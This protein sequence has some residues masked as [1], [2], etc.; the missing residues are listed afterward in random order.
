MGQRDSWGG[1][2]A[3]PA[4]PEARLPG[5]LSEPWGG[6][7][8]VLGAGGDVRPEEAPLGGA[9]PG[10]GVS[11]QLLTERRFNRSYL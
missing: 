10:A 2:G 11:E 1:G 7:G 6:A 3:W 8:L 5:V 4:P 9:G